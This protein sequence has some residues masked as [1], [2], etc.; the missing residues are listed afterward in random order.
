MHSK[1][2]GESFTRRLDRIARVA[3]LEFSGT[4]AR[5]TPVDTGALRAAVQWGRLSTGDGYFISNRLPYAQR[6]YL[7]GHSKQLPVGDFQAAVARLPNRIEIIAR[8][9]NRGS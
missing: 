9:V 4:M 1:K 8:G 5:M 2:V 3:A 6:I 7:E